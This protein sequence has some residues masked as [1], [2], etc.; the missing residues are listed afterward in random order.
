VCMMHLSLCKS[1]TNSFHL[2]HNEILWTALFELCACVCVCVWE[3]GCVC[4]YDAFKSVQKW[5]KLLSLI[6]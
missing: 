2:F 5:N 3:R 1:E 6:S 4:V